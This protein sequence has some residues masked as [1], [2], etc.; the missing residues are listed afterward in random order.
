M[1]Q[2]KDYFD[3]PSI[4]TI[5][6]F[7][8]DE[9]STTGIY[10]PAYQRRFSWGE[11]EYER[12]FE[13]IA[14]EISAEGQDNYYTLLGN[15][16]CFNDAYKDY[17]EPGEKREQPAELYNIVD[18]QQ[19]LSFIVLLSIALHQYI[20]DAKS[21]YAKNSI[22]ATEASRLQG[23][24]KKIFSV[25]TRNNPN[26]SP[27]VIRAI[28]DE[29][30]KNSSASD[31]TSPIARY[32]KQYLVY[33][34][35]ASKQPFEYDISDMLKDEKEKHEKFLDNMT[36]LQEIL[37]K[38]CSQSKKD[39]ESSAK[40]P[41]IK[42]IRRNDK[43]MKAF[44]PKGLA[45][46][47]INTR[48][49]RIFRA[50][51]LGN[52]ICK[53]ISL[54][55]IRAK[56]DYQRTFSIFSAIN[57]AGKLLNAFE[58]F[59]P[60]IVN[61]ENE[62]KGC[63]KDFAGYRSSPS[64][65]Y[66][67]KIANHLGKIGNKPNRDDVYAKELVTSFALSYSGQALEENLF[68]QQRFLNKEFN[69]IKIPERKREF[70]KLLY[71]VHK[72]RKLYDLSNIT[73]GS[74][75]KRPEE[76]QGI[77]EDLEAAVFC[78][79]FLHDSR[80]TLSIPILARYLYNM[81]EHEFDKESIQLFCQSIK[82][83]A[84]FCAL[85]RSSSGSSTSGIDDKLRE[86]MSYGKLKRKVGA[87][88]DQGELQEYFKKTLC[89]S[90]FT[91]QAGWADRVNETNMTSC[92]HVA[93]FILLVGFHNTCVKSGPRIEKSDDPLCN[94]TI[95]EKIFRSPT[96]ATL[97]HIIPVQE[98]NNEARYDPITK[99]KLWNIVF[100]PRGINSAVSN[101]TWPIKQKQYGVF[102]AGTK[103]ERE[104]K[105]KEL[106]E[107]QKVH[108]KKE[109]LFKKAIP[110]PA[111]SNM[112]RYLAMIDSDEH[113]EYTKEM[114]LERNKRLLELAWEILAEK[115]LGWKDEDRK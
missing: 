32:T 41:E 78:L 108:E 85:W 49:Q 46:G 111:F 87:Y 74:I 7:I 79:E 84:S 25:K 91:D 69:A 100:L 98:Q 57:S 96:Y 45:L 89:G 107:T 54:I 77:R 33:C 24:L 29:W 12:F 60:E 75:L 65:R 106:N 71:Y 26:P 6:A 50:I 56:K 11:N 8:G 37:R 66:I 82:Q 18:G 1:S 63:G 40:I 53:G 115:W 16:V 44:F 48:E 104:E 19:R 90:L 23:D 27:K 67:N 83:T 95:K 2:H 59:V 64:F 9:D 101:N 86:A 61:F 3:C 114:G 109:S 102:S 34:Q 36:S 72:A 70:V 92:K 105:I 112:T 103:D 15:I 28:E 42:K 38:F 80:F 22:L 76:P 21:T 20:T 10:I 47:E 58:I 43:L 35:E 51:L 93:K 97:E 99:D 110:E 52:Y 68:R 17:V 5:G 4:E 73:I 14:G 30:K 55:I 31:F 81:H 13:D 113:S 88:L 39:R 94:P 62:S